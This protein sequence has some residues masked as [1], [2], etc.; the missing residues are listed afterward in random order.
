MT[1][2]PASPGYGPGTNTGHGHVWERPDGMKARCGG[3]GVCAKCSLDAGRFAGRRVGPGKDPTPDTAAG[4]QL[5]ADA[6]PAV[7]A[8]GADIQGEKPALDET[9]DQHAVVEMLGHGMSIQPYYMDDTVTLYCGDC[10]DITHWLAADVLVTDP[11][12]GRGWKQGALEPSKADRRLGIAGDENTNA[13]DTALAMWGGRPAIVFGDLMLPP[14]AGTKQVGVYQKP[15]NA[16]LRGAIA[17]FRRDA[18]AWYLLGP[19]PSGLGRRSSILATRAPSQGNPSSPQGRYQH[20]HAKPLD[21]M[22]TLIAICPSGSIIADPF[23]GSGSTLVAAR[24]LGH[25]AIGVE[26]EEKWCEMAA[27]RLAQRILLI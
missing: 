7:S 3:P 18:E 15:P 14:P 19:W 1:T 21:V 25:R 10:R 24:N 5:G 8:P 20:P 4:A 13:R 11:P 9:F 16:G 22:E 2:E 17:G 23:A 12:Y 26:L 6:K 27:R